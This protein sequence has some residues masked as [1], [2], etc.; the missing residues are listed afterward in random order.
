MTLAVVEVLAGRGAQ[1]K[2]DLLEGVRQALVT[3]LQVPADD[4]IVRVIEHGPDSMLI[5]PRHSDRYTMVAIT[6]YYGRSLATKKRLYQKLAAELARLGVPADD[7]QVVVY[8]PPMEN[9]SIGG[10]PATDDPGVAARA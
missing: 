3:A 4:P 9:W 7:L 10:V 5:P 2:R 6:M 1:E 8:E